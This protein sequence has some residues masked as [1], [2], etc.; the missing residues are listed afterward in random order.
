MHEAA[1]SA[2]V[3]P[4]DFGGLVTGCRDRGSDHATAADCVRLGRRLLEGHD[5]LTALETLRDGLER[6]PDDVGLLQ[7]MSLAWSRAGMPE[8]AVHILGKLVAAGQRDAETIGLLAA[9]RKRIGLAVGSQGTAHIRSARA[10]YEEAYG[11][12]R[13]TWLGINAATLARLLGDEACAI[14]VARDVIA[15]CHEKLAASA[16]EG[17]YWISAT[18][19]EAALV[20]DDLTAAEEWARRSRCLVG[21][22]LGMLD[23]TRRQFT[24]LLEHAGHDPRLVDDWLPMPAVVLFAGHMFDLPGRPEPRFPEDRCSAVAA[25]IR[26][27]VAARDVGCGFSS[28]A[29]GGDILSQEALAATGAERCVV[30]PFPEDAFLQRSVD[31]NGSGDWGGRFRRVIAGA[32][33]ICASRSPLWRDELSFDYSNQLIIGLA[34]SR[35][36]QLGAALEALVVWNGRRGDGGGGTASVVSTCQRLGIPVRTIDPLTHLDAARECSVGERAEAESAGTVAA[37]RS[38][39]AVLFADAV[40]FSRLPD[41]QVPLFVDVFLGR[42][43]TVVD[44]YGPE[45]ITVRETWGDGLFFVFPRLEDAALFSLDVAELV[46]GTD[47]LSEGF[48]TQLKLRT[49]LH[50]GPMYPVRDPITGRSAVCGA[51]IAQGARLEPKTPPGRVYAT[52]AFAARAALEG[53]Q[54]FRCAFV[55][56]LD[57]DKRYGTF[58]AYV[59]SRTARQ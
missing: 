54:S 31:R 34:R 6:W 28:A 52:E 56:Q 26:N 25:T 19:A 33:L 3:S 8:E 36:V 17:D 47:W 11:R 46:N 41:G 5:L 49:A 44:R 24:T 53:H 23:T 37:D 50:H 20:L 18:M 14:A 39:G 59:V 51:H 13:T 35:A 9:A 48:S 45:R 1:M 29:C 12:E 40:G 7:A 22:R 55:G 42:I 10:L 32:R 30:L 4:Q 43:A 15:L 57:F 16:G 27:W 2:E 58:P 38:L 21:G